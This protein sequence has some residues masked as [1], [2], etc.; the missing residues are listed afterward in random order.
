M[1]VFKML[2]NM[3]LELMCEVYDCSEL[4]FFY[5]KDCDCFLCG[6]CV[7]CDYVGYKIRKVFEVV[8]S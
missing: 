6:D 2:G 8:E 4:L 3:N 1:V 5:C 7:I